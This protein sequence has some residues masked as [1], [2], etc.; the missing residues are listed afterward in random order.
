[1]LP[2]DSLGSSTSIGSSPLS[3]FPSRKSY[4]SS[5]MALFREGHGIGDDGNGTQLGDASG[6]EG[7]GCEAALTRA[8]FV[9]VTETVGEA[10]LITGS[11]KWTLKER[12]VKVF[13]LD[14]NGCWAG[15]AASMSA[16][17][18]SGTWRTTTSAEKGFRGQMEGRG[19]GYGAGTINVITNVKV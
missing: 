13:V 3:S 18:S 10:F 11:L 6:K 2:F 7:E 9:F 12:V 1:M 8:A 4:P 15:A 14:E 16:D 17:G 19:Q 5:L